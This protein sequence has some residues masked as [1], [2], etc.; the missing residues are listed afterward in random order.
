MTPIQSL[1]KLKN[2]CSSH[3][4]LLRPLNLMGVCDG[5]G[6]SLNQSVYFLIE[7]L[8]KTFLGKRI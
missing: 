8:F 6:G 4:A 2:V 1:H 5:V 3:K 7:L